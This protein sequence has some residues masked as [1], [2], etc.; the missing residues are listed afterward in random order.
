VKVKV[1]LVVLVFQFAM[2][3]P[4]FC[5]DFATNP[6]DAKKFHFNAGAE[7]YDAEVRE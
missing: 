1:Q 7:V 6:A 3:L 2:I 4:C 5:H